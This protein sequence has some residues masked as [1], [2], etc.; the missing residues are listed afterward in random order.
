MLALV[1]PGPNVM[2]YLS[3]NTE[4]C[5]FVIEKDEPKTSTEKSMAKIGY[6]KSDNQIGHMAT[7]IAASVILAVSVAA[8]VALDAP[9]LY[10]HLKMMVR[11]VSYG[12]RRLRRRGAVS[13]MS[14]DTAVSQESRQTAV[15]PESRQTAVS[16]ES[17][18]TAVSPESR[19]T[20]VSPES[21]QTAVSPESHQTGVSPESHQTAMSPE[22]HQTSVSPDSHSTAVSMECLELDISLQCLDIA[23]SR[24]SHTTAV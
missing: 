9:L 21:R 15:S 3:E 10:A 2:V 12:L 17:H 7:G 24:D 1:A 11:N 6:M 22:S 23:V 20:A 19:Q 8:V 18:Q 4:G 5:G 14:H 16:P 13:P